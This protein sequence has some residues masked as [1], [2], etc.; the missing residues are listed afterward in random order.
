M[1]DGAG[2][3]APKPTKFMD[4]SEAPTRQRTAENDSVGAG[5][6]PAGTPGPPSD[7]STPGGQ[8]RLSAQQSSFD[9]DSVLRRAHELMTNGVTAGASTTKTGGVGK[10]GG[11]S[12]QR[13]GDGGQHDTTH[14]NNEMQRLLAEAE[15]EK[16]VEQEQIKRLRE[17]AKVRRARIA[18]RQMEIDA[19]AAAVEQDA[20]RAAAQLAVDEAEAVLLLAKE[21]LAATPAKETGKAAA[22]R[23]GHSGRGRSTAPDAPKWSPVLPRHLNKLDTPRGDRRSVSLVFNEI[24]GSS[25]SEE[26]NGEDEDGEETS[27]FK[28][29]SRGSVRHHS[30]LSTSRK[31]D[32]ETASERTR[33]RKGPRH[34][35]DFPSYA[36]VTDE[37]IDWL[38]GYC[39][40]KP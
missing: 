12:G 40:A 11:D 14:S 3:R 7:A 28:A 39:E 38:K 21:Q 24:E 5:S 36:G 34:K 13:G 32:D 26:S 30:Q 35:I 37:F 15:Q 9:R 31:L 33:Q 6:S 19:A 16:A 22:V 8:Q 20:Y 4:G 25:D 17:E 29:R 18:Q 27:Q 1:A 23:H 10:Q 2:K